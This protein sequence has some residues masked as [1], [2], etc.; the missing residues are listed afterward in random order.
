MADLKT[1][2]LGFVMNSPVI[3]ASGTVGYGVEYE[4]LADFAKIGGISGK[5]AVMGYIIDY[6]TM[7]ADLQGCDIT[8]AEWEAFANDFDESLNK[9]QLYLIFEPDNSGRDYM[10]ETLTYGTWVHQ[11][12]SLTDKICFDKNGKITNTFTN[13]GESGQVV[14]D[15]SVIGN[16]L[17]LVNPNGVEMTIR[18]NLFGDQMIVVFSDYTILYDRK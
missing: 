10:K 2:L 9:A 5:D 8:R 4:E 18:I 13:D 15:Y 14:Y 7:L 11:D 16:K 3:G 1:N 6:C 17:T 12:E